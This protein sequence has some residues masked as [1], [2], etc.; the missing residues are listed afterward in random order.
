MQTSEKITGVILA[1]GRGS[2]MG[3]VDKGLVLLQNQP[4]IQH[5]ISRLKPQ[6][7]EIIINANRKIAQ[8]QAFGFTVIQDESADFIGPLAGL[9]LLLCVNSAL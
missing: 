9:Q 5:V 6:V 7:D 2:R 1:G 3:G 4:L 8:Y